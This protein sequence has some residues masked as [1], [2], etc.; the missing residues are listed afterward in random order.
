MRNERWLAIALIVVGA[1]ALLSNLGDNAGWI[2]VGL[3]AAAFLAAYV[4]Q[5][6]Y[7]FLVVGCILGGIALGILLENA[8][9]WEGAFLISLGVGFFA[10]D[11]VE[12][13]ASRWPLYLAAL[14]VGLGIFSSLAESGILS[15]L[16]FAVLLIAVGAFLLYQNR[17]KERSGNWVEVDSPAAS[18]SSKA[19]VNTQTTATTVPPT[20]PPV[21]ETSLETPTADQAA[22]Q[23]N[24]REAT[25]PV[26][27]PDIASYETPP[28]TATKAETETEPLT[29]DALERYEQLSNWRRET[30]RTE[31]VSAY[32]VLNNATIER[33]ARANPQTLETLND[34]KGIGPIKLERYGEAILALLHGPQNKSSQ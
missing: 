2:W 26:T 6:N 14:F 21:Q 28:D 22:D 34:I 30:A 31:D 15:S 3:I 17:D 19:S 32:L 5:R 24:A 18:S 10:I 29:P 23:S 20:S 13:R 7:G 25:K 33:I 1:L 12:P 27:S 16:W 4:A 11:R 9:N 8:W